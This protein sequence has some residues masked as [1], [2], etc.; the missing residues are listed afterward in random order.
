MIQLRTVQRCM[1]AALFSLLFSDAAE[2]QPPV[3]GDNR[4]E[5]GEGCDDGNTDDGDGCSSLC[6]IEPGFVCEEV[7]FTVDVE[8]ELNQGGDQINWVL[9]ADERGIFETANSE[10]GIYSTNMPA[11]VTEIVFDMRVETTN[12]D[13]F[14][15]W[16]V[17][18]DDG[19]LGTSGTPADTDFL[20]FS[21][22]QQRQTANGA[23]RWSGMRLSRVTGNAGQAEFWSGNQGNVTR[24]ADGINFPVNEALTSGSERVNGWED[25]RWYRVNM[26][27]T[28]T[29]IRIWLRAGNTTA[30]DDPTMRGFSALDRVAD[31]E[32]DE[33]IAVPPGNFGFYAYSQ[34]S[35]RYDLVGPET[36]S[37]CSR[38]DDDDGVKNVSDLDSDRDGILDRDEMPGFTDDPDADTD[39]DGIP[40]WNDP[41]NV[42]GGC[43]AAGMT[44]ASLPEALDVDGDGIPNHLDLD[45]DNDGITD[46]YEAGLIDDDGD[47]NPD[48]CT[49]VTDQGE[50]AAGGLSGSPT[51]T[52]DATPPDFLNP[53]SDGDG[54]SDFIEAHDDNGD[55]VAD[56]P[57]APAGADFDGD[58]ID[59][60]FDPDCTVGLCG[61]TPI[62]VAAVL[63]AAQDA[64]GDGTPDWQTGCGD[65]YL[66]GGEGCDDGNLNNTDACNN[67]CLIT[68]GNACSRNDA[69]ASMTCES[70]T[71]S[72]QVCDDTTPAGIDQGCSAG[73][74]ACIDVALAGGSNRCVECTVDAQCG[75]GAICDANA[76][77]VC[78]D[79]VDGNGTDR[80]CTDVAP[81]CDASGAAP[82]CRVCVDDADG[83]ADTG[84]AAAVPVCS[85]NPS[86]NRCVVCEDD[87]TG[88]TMDFGCNATD[89]M[90]CL[91]PIG[92]PP[93]CVECTG[94]DDCTAMGEVCGGDNTCVPGCN[95]P[96]DC[97]GDLPIC[98]TVGRTCVECLDTDECRGDL[99]C[100][101]GGLCEFADSDMDGVPDDVDLDDDNDGILDA[102][103]GEGTDLS[104]DGDDD[105]IP[106]YRDPDAVD[107][108]DDG[109]GRCTTLP[110][111]V[112][113]DGDG[114]PNHLDLDSD[115][116]GIA[117]VIEAGG[118]DDD[119]DG[120]V[121]AF[122]D[123]DR[124]GVDD[125]LDDDPLP[126]P[127]TDEDTAPDFLDRDADG[128]GLTDAF[129]AGAED[130]DGDGIP[131][132]AFQDADMN[133]WNDLL[134]GGD[135]LPRPDADGDGDPDHID[136]DADGDGVPDALEGH[137]GT[138]AA[139]ADTDGDGIDDA[140]DPDCIDDA[141]GGVVGEIAA[142][143]STDED[144][145]PDF[146]DIDADGDGITDGV[147]CPMPVSCAD[148]DEDGT[149]DFRSLDADGDGLDDAVE[150]H[151]DDHDG[152]ADV[153]PAGVD[154]DGD[155]LD[156]AFDPDCIEDLCGGVVGAEAT[157]PDLDEDGMPDFQDADDD[158]DGRPTA[159]EIA[160]AAAYEG[161]ADEPTDIDGDGIANWFEEDADGDGATDM[162]ENAGD[163]DINDDG[164]LDYLDPSVAPVDTDGDGIPDHVECGGSVL[165]CNT[166]T[167]GDGLL[168]F[169]D[170][171]DDNDGIST[172]E[173]FEAQD[174]SDGDPLNDHDADD[175]GVPNH[176]DLDSDG[177][178]I[179]D[180]W[181]NGGRDLDANGDGRPD[182]ASDAD[183]DGVLAAFDSN[184]SDAARGI[185][186][187][188]TNTDGNGQADYLDLDADDD[189]LPDVREAD[190][191]D[192]DGDGQ[193]DNVTDANGDGLADALVSS[194]LPLTD[195]NDDGTPDFQSTDSDGDGRDDLSESRDDNGDGAADQVPS[196]TDADGDGIDDA[197]DSERGGVAA[198]EP[199]TDEDGTPD[200][201]D[202]DDDGDGLPTADEL[203]ED[204]DGD[205]VRNYLDDDDDGDGV[206]TSFEGA[207]EGQDTDGDGRPDY[208]DP[209]DD[210]DGV[211]TVDEMADP[212]GDGDPADA[213]DD[214]GNGTPNYLQA[215]PTFSG[216]VAGGAACA[217]APLPASPFW[218]L[219]GLGWL[220][221]RRRRG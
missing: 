132:G 158:G 65:A 42:P 169:E 182:D 207:D 119:S 68:D 113:F 102:D 72:C 84:C 58:G 208:L 21:W 91:T 82:V 152:V 124:N 131:D 153:T 127:D 29:R 63:T 47:G 219:L 114:I 115:N 70:E 79:D 147:E 99:L 49:S 175:D 62:T 48:A 105:G 34:P 190:G 97:A 60:A 109:T 154:T 44:C 78:T 110:A 191:T 162:T 16:T 69:C 189:G 186:R 125:D 218:A 143:P 10:V 180:L 112:D 197:F 194:P 172:R 134:S 32:F 81:I 45:S 8:G 40:D 41:D 145:V 107:C 185:E 144:G 137:D 220:F 213:A 15:G 187:A 155:G 28:P 43:M 178:G 86:G 108:T 151:D 157:T 23:T 129:E 93:V 165:D 204:T 66:L 94:D 7:T 167:D 56:G 130:A 135:A 18:F 6:A 24:I 174:F 160:D 188:A 216:G 22:K 36:D 138:E 59:D 89:A 118:S 57:A 176:L 74:P 76:C 19:E 53:D 183:G 14:F 31:L 202:I 128:D 101:A 142:V 26:V 13:D 64:N 140:F 35:L 96:S 221:V 67:V 33:S 9:D 159:D 173:E 54:L 141:C 198:S 11:D 73:T 61:V 163:G 206:G 161:P 104:L 121:D 3:C 196:G 148:T 85:T 95:E 209:D 203:D 77:V 103:E 92:E 2:A 46:A 179:P 184:D 116:D 217:A 199:D 164:L 30:T 4:L 38:D 90:L 215:T 5:T 87:A 71:M 210:D 106:D 122:D 83:G 1:L 171:D 39:L 100:G 123:A 211:P 50:C 193:H 139:G 12:D 177:D 166:D 27:A 214:D 136:L 80:G 111:N 75:D 212:N 192:A 168:D 20:L 201:R 170:P 88:L 195:T 25:N 120:Q 117:D 200:W 51:N 181:E 126:V 133:G 37:V 149:P 17:G 55:A 156:D 205:G 146:R 98:D 150:G 52:V